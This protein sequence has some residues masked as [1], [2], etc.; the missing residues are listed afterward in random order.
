MVVSIH[1]SR[2]FAEWRREALAGLQ[3][4]IDPYGLE[5]L[6]R[7]GFEL[8]QASPLRLDRGPAGL[9]RSLERRTRLRLRSTLAGARV[10]RQADLALALLEP[11]SYA[12]SQ[13]ARLHV[14]PWSATPLAALICWL[15][16]DFRVAGPAMRAWLRRCV[17]GT[18]LFIYLSS[19]QRPILCEQLGIPPERLCHVHFGIAADYFSPRTERPRE[20]YVLAAGIDRGRDYRTFL[21]AVARLDHPVKLL[22][23][24][25]Q[26]RGLEVPANV[27]AMGFVEKP[28]YRELLRDAA[29]VVVPVRP[30]VAYPTG[31]SVLLAAM[32]CEV[33]TVVTR[34]DALADYTRH[35]SNTWT[36]PGEDAEAL[37]AGIERVL[38]DPALAKKIARGGRRDVQ[39]DFNT[40]AMW[41]KLAPRL[42][43]LVQS[44]S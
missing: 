31:Q 1:S 26:L 2:D 14:P 7:L 4:S 6:S 11:Q 41:Q 35:G 23:P 37:L 36:V 30:A 39:S 32:S 20:P 16:D 28:R 5:H 18:D 3:P 25:L 9:L 40:A 8:R 42:R 24:L 22:C 13:L 19:N 17:R 27:E 29:L 21:A 34:T 38:G 44:R 15:A 43:A 33:P 12:Y 10:S